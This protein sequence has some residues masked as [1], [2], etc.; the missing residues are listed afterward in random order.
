MPEAKVSLQAYLQSAIITIPEAM[1][2]ALSV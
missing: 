2:I 1:K